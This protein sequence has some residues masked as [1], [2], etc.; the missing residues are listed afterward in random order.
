LVS[1]DV[2]VTSIQKL[3]GHRWIESTQTYVA[4]NDPQVQADY[5]AASARLESWQPLPE[6]AGAL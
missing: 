6:A 2:P 1:V 4:A 5:F 3:L